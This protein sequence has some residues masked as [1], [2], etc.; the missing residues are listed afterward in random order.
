MF[1][2]G[3]TAR[4]ILLKYAYGLEPSRLSFGI[5][6]A[7]RV[8]DWRNVDR[9]AEVLT[10]GHEFQ[11]TK[12]GFRFLRRTGETLDILP[13]GPI[14]G[15]AGQFEWPLTEGFVFSVIGFEAAFNA[16]T[17]VIL[18]Q[19]P[20]IELPVCSL[21]GLAMLKLISWDEAR[22]ARSKD[23]EDFVYIREDLWWLGQNIGHRRHELLNVGA[24]KMSV[25]VHC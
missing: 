19:N 16:A 25:M 11:S 12:L 7:I 10:R 2:V 22:T 9:F 8:G 14:A 4:D 21:A 23:A 20:Y 13:F 5:D 1:V 15:T 6:V 3:A 24:L 17:R 18:G